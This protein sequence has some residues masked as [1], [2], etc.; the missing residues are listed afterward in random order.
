MIILMWLFYITIVFYSVVD[1]FQTRVLLDMGM[2]ELNPILNWL[3]IKT[4]TIN[5]IFVPKIFWLGFLLTFLILKT[6]EELQK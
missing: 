3:I 4:G 5:S 2:T 6:E 1:A